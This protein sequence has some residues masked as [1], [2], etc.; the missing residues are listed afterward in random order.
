M[1]FQPWVIRAC[2]LLLCLLGSTLVQAQMTPVGRWH[3]IDDKTGE[4]KGLVRIDDI[5]GVLIGHVEK[6]LRKDTDPNALCTEC[7]GER[8]DKPV[9]GMEVIRGAKKVEGKDVWEG[10]RILDPENGKEYTLRLT[11]VEGGRKLEV[12]GSF[13]FF[14]RT[15]TWN[16]VP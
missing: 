11:P 13:A 1:N 2:V 8:K 16:R 10:G 3:N 14:W 15:Q 9:L 7:S 5:D 12:R 4:I 6:V